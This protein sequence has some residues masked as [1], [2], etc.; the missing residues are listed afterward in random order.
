MPFT[1]FHFGPS[2]VVGLPLRRY[3]DL[4]ALL[5]ANI[6]IDI[7][8]LLVMFFNWNY[9]LHGIAHSF[10]GATGV[11]VMLGVVLSF[12]KRPLTL[13]MEQWLR[14][15]YATSTTKLVLSAIAGGWLHVV[16]DALIYP[17][18]RPFLPLEGNPFSTGM[19]SGTVYLWCGV[20]LLPASAIYFVSAWQDGRKGEG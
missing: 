8:P 19:G 1:P 13:V 12:C 5:L 4:P 15:S 6:A 16:L 10:V 17:G 18:M 20:S 3:I 11:G 7:E 14:L 2:A 9:P